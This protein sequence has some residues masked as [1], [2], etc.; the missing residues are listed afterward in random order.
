MII[1]ILPT[2]GERISVDALLSLPL[3]GDMLTAAMANGGSDIELVQYEERS[4]VSLW[5]D[6]S[7]YALDA[8]L[9]QAKS[10]G[11]KVRDNRRRLK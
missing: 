10:A 8:V 5:F 2:T 7:P 9:A 4:P 11:V 3:A 6:V 1:D